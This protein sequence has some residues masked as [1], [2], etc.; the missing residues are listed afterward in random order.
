[1]RRILLGAL[2][3]AIALTGMA[4][5]AA[6][7]NPP[8]ITSPP[9]IE[10]TTTGEDQRMYDIHWRPDGEMLAVTVGSDIALFNRDLQEVG[11]LTGHTDTVFAISWN[12]DGTRL[13]SGGDDATIRVWDMV[14]GSPNYAT[15]VQTFQESNRV[16]YLKWSPNV[17]EPFL[18]ALI[19]DQLL[20]GSDEA[21]LGRV[22]HIW[23]IQTNQLSASFGPA[24]SSSRE[25][26]WS[27]DGTQIA[28]AG[29]FDYPDYSLK[30]WNISTSQIIAEMNNFPQRIGSIAWRSNPSQLIAATDFLV[31]YDATTPNLEFVTRIEEFV[32]AHSLAISPSEQL[33]ALIDEDYRLVIG[34]IDTG[35]NLV[36][37]TDLADEGA[38]RVA[39]H[40]TG[41]WLASLNGFTNL[42]LWDVSA[43]P[44][45]G[46]PTLIPNPTA[47]PFGTP[48]PTDVLGG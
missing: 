24:Y 2:F 17:S 18:A 39:W 1:M 44:P 45:S 10:F 23:N 36:E 27:P 19:N 41:T 28:L 32:L 40:P 46:L 7:P 48:A 25:V 38:S 9:Y 35:T 26:I 30:V 43:I 4:V 3:A 6:D 15:S 13:A 12:A 22:V 47:T 42:R 31:V 16:A 21:I 29:I 33:F 5:T 34:E 14:A 20:T 37:I 8:I 11:R